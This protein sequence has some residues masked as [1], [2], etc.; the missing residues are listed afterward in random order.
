MFIGQIL[1]SIGLVLL[2]SSPLAFIVG[3][4]MMWF[5]YGV[6]LLGATFV[7]VY[8]ATNRKAV[9]KMLGSRSASLVAISAATVAAFVAVVVALNFIAYKNPKEFDLTKDGLFTLADQTTKTL[10]GLKEEVKVYA[11][12]RSDDPQFRGAKETLERYKMFSPKFTYEL[13]D[14]MQSPELVEKFQ[15][16]EGGSRLVFTAK[17]QNEARPKDLTEQE[18]TTALLKVTSSS[19]KKIYF[20]AGHGEPGIE[21]ADEQGL[22]AAAGLLKNEG[23]VVES[24]SFAAAGAVQAGEKI[25]LNATAPMSGAAPTVPADARVVIVTGPE[26]E[27]T[28]PELTALSKWIERGGKLLMGLEPKKVTGLERLASMWHVE[29]RNDLIVDVNPVNRLLGMGPAM[30]LVQTYEPHAITNNFRAPI[31]LPTARSLYLK[32]TGADKVAG[33]SA[34]ALAQTGKSSWGETDYAGGNAEFTEG[35]DAKGPVTI[36]AISTK[37]A[38]SA[39]DKVSEEGRLVVFGDGEWMANRFNSFQGN[40]D[41]FVNTVNW[42]ADEESKISIRPKNRA[43]SRIF[44]TESQAA[45]F[46]IS[47]IYLL[48]VS[49]FAL[50][51]TIRQLRRRK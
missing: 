51:M 31:A 2:L 27:L 45:V 44:L 34:K 40:A 3:R 46:K 14:P 43:A 50:G 13:I 8:Y 4:D 24:F 49:L 23:Y 1:G 22:A 25:D 16:R 48:P 7:G 20:L 5:V 26:T 33:A 12:Y 39:A 11:F 10:E 19:Q 35:K 18:L 28:A 6:V 37:S 30:A 47:S 41:F 36:A 32:D 38:A 15:I 29:V 21:Q 9:G 42:L 17:N